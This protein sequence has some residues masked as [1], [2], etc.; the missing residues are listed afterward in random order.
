MT[1]KYRL[2]ERTCIKPDD[3]LE[4]SLHEAG[5]EIQYSGTPARNMVV[6]NDEARTAQAVIAPL[7]ASSRNVLP[8]RGSPAA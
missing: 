6:L 3:H 4:A 1:A 2:T 7:N 8:R 5:A